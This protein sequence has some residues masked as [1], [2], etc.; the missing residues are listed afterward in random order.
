M[1]EP[2]MIGPRLPAT[3]ICGGSLENFQF[4]ENSRNL[5]KLF[6]PNSSPYRIM[7]EDKEDRTLELNGRAVW[8]SERAS[9][10]ATSGSQPPDLGNSA[11]SDGSSDRM[12]LGHD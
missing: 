12:I 11:V 6:P 3:V 5:H 9:R 10:R 1:A 8:G 7:L 2:P 4:R